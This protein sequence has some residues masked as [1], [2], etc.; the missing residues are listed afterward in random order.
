MCWLSWVYK[1]ILTY[2]C[3]INSELSRRTICIQKIKKT[4]KLLLRN[5][6][7]II[8]CTLGMSRQAQPRPQKKSYQ[9]TENIICIQK[10]NFIPCLLHEILCLKESCNLNGQ[11][12]LTH[13]SGTRILLDMWFPQKY[14]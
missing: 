9:L 11:S 6:R 10:V 2:D 3:G 1:N 12:I 4:N 13:N 5:Y 8:L 14:S 7:F